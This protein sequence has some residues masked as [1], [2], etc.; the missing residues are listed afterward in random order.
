MGSESLSLSPVKLLQPEEALGGSGAMPDKSL[1]SAPLHWHTPHL[2]CPDTAS[3]GTAE[4][5]NFLF[6]SILI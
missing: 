6:P 1:L 3:L 5:I 2:P 4:T